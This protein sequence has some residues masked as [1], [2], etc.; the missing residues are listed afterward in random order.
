M[1]TREMDGNKNN[2]LIEKKHEV[3]I[4]LIIL[5]SVR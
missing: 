4:I 5:L 1:P 2:L 3:K